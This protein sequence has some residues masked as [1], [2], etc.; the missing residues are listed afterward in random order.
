MTESVIR[1]YTLAE[2]TAWV[3]MPISERYG[4][5]DL[6]ERRVI[7]DIEIRDAVI[8]ACGLH[9][10]ADFQLLTLERR[11]SVVREKE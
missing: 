8:K 11:K 4:C 5:I 1:R 7:P 2:L 10:I 6:D 9:S 3:D